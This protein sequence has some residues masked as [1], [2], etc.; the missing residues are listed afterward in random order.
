MVLLE[1]ST[2]VSQLVFKLLDQAAKDFQAWTTSDSNP[3]GIL[4]VYNQVILHLLGSP[5]HTSSETEIP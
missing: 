3:W 2:R 1:S 5:M 4:L